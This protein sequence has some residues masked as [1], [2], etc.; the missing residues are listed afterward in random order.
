MSK[1]IPKYTFW[2]GVKA[3]LDL[4]RTALEEVQALKR[5]PGPAGRDGLS[6]QHFD[7]EVMDDG[8]TILLSLEDEK[9]SFKVELSFPV[10]IYRGVFREGQEYKQGDTVTWGGDMWHCDTDTKDKPDG[11]QRCWTLCV[12][13]GRSK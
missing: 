1:L 12:R 2:E 3:A 8:R 6:I 13:K 9:H 10:M 11:E 7:A 5:I 4:G